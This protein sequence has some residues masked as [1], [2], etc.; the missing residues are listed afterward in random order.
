MSIISAWLG[1]PNLRQYLSSGRC[2]LWR[3]V[4]STG[5]PTFLDCMSVW[6]QE[7]IVLH[8][9]R[10]RCRSQDWKI[11]IP[12]SETLH[13]WFPTLPIG[14]PGVSRNSSKEIHY[15][16]LSFLKYPHV[17]HSTMLWPEVA[18]GRW[19]EVVYV[20]RKLSIHQRITGSWNSPKLGEWLVCVHT[21][22]VGKSKRGWYQLLKNLT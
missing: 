15:N 5:L 2:F 14:S 8:F 12:R 16:S 1:D 10:R 7:P 17:Q 11:S 19:Q 13:Y 18:Q 21:C 3:M 6:G 9:H 4:S 20:S 22:R